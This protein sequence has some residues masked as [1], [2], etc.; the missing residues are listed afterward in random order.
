MYLGPMYSFLPDQ[1]TL[2]FP[3]EK[4]KMDLPRTII[5]KWRVIEI[6]MM[7]DNQVLIADDDY[8][9]RTAM[10]DMVSAWGYDV[11]SAKHGLDVW[12]ILLQEDAPKLMILDWVMPG[13]NGVEICRRLRDRG[14]DPYYYIILVTVQDQIEHLAE[15]LASGADDY[16]TKPVVPE[17]LEA[18]LLVG[19]RI[20]DLQ[21]QLI[22]ARDT[23]R[24]QA[25]H[26]PLT[27][28]WNRKGILE[29]MRREL[30]RASRSGLALSVIMLDLDYF[31]QANDTYGH[32]AGD[33][34]LIE[35][36]ERMQESI[37]SYDAVGRMGGDEFLIVLPECNTESALY[38]AER[39]RKHLALSNSV[40]PRDAF[41]V[42]ASMGVASTSMGI[43][44]DVNDLIL[45]AD[46]ALMQAK[47]MGRDRV[48]LRQS[49]YLPIM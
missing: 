17:E 24:I 23:L 48:E 15:G 41:P 25:T 13:I 10:E 34:L 22:A 20:L 43:G 12:E 47:Q 42:T 32:L 28:L 40:L 27:N 44:L 39:I 19:Q 4:P 35:I 9:F 18:R 8:N 37:R 1:S 36:A 2:E 11:Q 14:E 46:S 3:P 6:K 26:D 38:L 33:Q 30:S 7:N 49:A 21:A 45:A 31:K 16:L 5:V 29:I